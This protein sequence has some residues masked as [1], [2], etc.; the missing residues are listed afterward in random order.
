MTIRFENGTVITLG[1]NNRVLLNSSVVT[2]GENI[3]AVGTTSDMKQRYLKGKAVDCT[4]KIVLPGFIC[5]HHHFHNGARHGY[6]G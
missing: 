4:G 6:S 5:T 2:E 3:I 1:P